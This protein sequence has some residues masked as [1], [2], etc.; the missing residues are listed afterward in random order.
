MAYNDRPDAI[1]PDCWIVAAKDVSGRSSCRW[2][3]S[4]VSYKTTHFP[5]LSEVTLRCRTNSKH[6]FLDHQRAKKNSAEWEWVL[7]KSKRHSPGFSNDLR[8]AFQTLDISLKHKMS[9]QCGSYI[10]DYYPIEDNDCWFR[11][12]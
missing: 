12:E 1:I 7:A 9:V 2:L 8:A 6:Q 5:Q 3:R 10:S 11:R 4:L